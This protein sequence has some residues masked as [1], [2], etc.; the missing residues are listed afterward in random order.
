MHKVQIM[1]HKA[2]I[3]IGTILHVVR[4]SCQTLRMSN[5][6]HCAPSGRCY[7]YSSY[8][9]YG[10][11]CHVEVE[12]VPCQNHEPDALIGACLHMHACV[13][14]VYGIVQKQWGKAYRSRSSLMCGMY[15]HRTTVCAGKAWRLLMTNSLGISLTHASTLARARAHA[16]AHTT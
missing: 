16:R 11:H 5:D 6:L 1:M 14:V 13:G 12:H 3:L 9:R 2:R 4:W 10:S 15:L 7:L 8:D